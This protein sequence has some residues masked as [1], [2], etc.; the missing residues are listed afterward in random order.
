MKYRKLVYHV[1]VDTNIPS[2]PFQMENTTAKGSSN[3]NKLEIKQQLLEVI[4]LCEANTTPTQS[5]NQNPPDDDLIIDLVEAFEF[6]KGSKDKQL[7]T[8]IGMQMTI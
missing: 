2:N 1:E 7:S 4:N 6:L 8:I 3:F 5:S